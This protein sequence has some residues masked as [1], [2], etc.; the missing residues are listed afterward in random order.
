MS[1]DVVAIGGSAG[2]IEALRELVASLPSDFRPSILVVIHMPAHTRSVLPAI[3]ERGG[4]LPAAHAVDGEPL[5]GGRIY[6]APPDRHLLVR[7]GTV[8]LGRGPRENGHRPAVDVLFRSVARWYGPAAIGVVLSGALDDGAAGAAVVARHGGRVVV[9]EPT[10][11][12]YDGM[13]ASA[14]RADDPDAVVPVAAMAALLVEWS[15]EQVHAPAPHSDGDLVVETDVADMVDA[16]LD[17]PQRP[18]EPVPL[19]CPDCSGPLYEISTDVLRF[20]CRVGHAWSPDSLAAQQVEGA[21]AALWMAVRHLEEKAELHHRLAE[22][23]ASR[24]SRTADRHT[25]R[26]AEAI[27]AA[28]TIRQLLRVRVTDASIEAEAEAEVEAP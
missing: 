5:V 14:I 8:V 20:R 2:G 21:E 25:E 3:L 19:S 6:V 10:E 28:H 7:D 22:A 27:A 11:A 23:A 24:G 16:A 17:D 26:A 4:P 12:L 1:R 15:R 13:P 18:G 9:Q